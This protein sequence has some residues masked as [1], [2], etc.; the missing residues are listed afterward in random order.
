M[1]M[2]S[3][4]PWVWAGAAA[5]VSC[6]ILGPEEEGEAE[7]RVAD[8]PIVLESPTQTVDVTHLRLTIRNTGRTR[9]SYSPCGNVLQ[10][11]DDEGP[12]TVWSQGCLTFTSDPIIVAPGEEFTEEVQVGLRNGGV[13]VDR[14]F[15]RV[16]GDYQLMTLL[17]WDR[18]NEEALPQEMQ[19]S[20]TFRVE[21]R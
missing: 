4:I 3:R 16:S 19:T 10:R 8:A 21:E 1:P 13:Y 14:W 18:D 7:V 17:L 20:N 9:L 2:N 11:V 15:E 12:T 5:M 6:G